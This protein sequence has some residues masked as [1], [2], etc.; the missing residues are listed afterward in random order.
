MFITESQRDD[1]AVSVFA[2]Q[3][4]DCFG[5]EPPVHHEFCVPERPAR[6]E[7]FHTLLVDTGTTICPVHE[8]NMAPGVIGYKDIDLRCL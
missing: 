4:K 5:E 3:I 2:H 1:V 7:I 8:G 6:K